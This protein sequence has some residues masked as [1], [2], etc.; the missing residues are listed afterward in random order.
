M[1]IS[2]AVLMLF[3][4]CSCE[5][6]IDFNL[7]T[8]EPVLVADAQIENGEAPVVVLTKSLGYFSKIDP[9]ILAG[10]FIRNAEVTISN[11][12]RTHRLKEYGIPLAPGFT[13]YFYSNDPANPTTLFNGELNKN[14]SLQILSEGKTYTATTTIPANNISLDSIWVRVAPQNPDTAKRVLFL[15][16]TDPS[17]LGNYGRYFTKLNSE[18]FLPGENSVF[19]DQ[20]IDGTTFSAQLPKGIDRNDPPKPDSNF[21]RRGDTITMKFCNIS[22]ESFRFWSTWEFAFQGIGNPFAQPN[23]VI[24]NIS[25]GA[26]GAFCGYA[27][28]YKRIVAQ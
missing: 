11:G 23:K 25:N 14:Y 8:A 1:K 3:C 13:A 17:G 9:Q 7:K 4:L 12:T 10:S 5:K 21:F 26:L 27:V 20:V 2:V 19:E 22:R 24:G 16:A 15:Q 28:Q 18:R 6:N